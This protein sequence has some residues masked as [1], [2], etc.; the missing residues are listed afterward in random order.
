MSKLCAQ[1]D[2]HRCTSSSLQDQ[3]NSALNAFGQSSVLMQKDLRRLNN[4][5]LAL[6]AD[7]KTLNALANEMSSNL[8]HVT[9]MAEQSNANVFDLEFDKGSQC[10]W[11]FLQNMYRSR[12]KMDNQVACFLIL[13]AFGP[14]SD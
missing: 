4:R 13:V 12:Q 10:R 7:L 9:T 6:T 1:S 5:T 3:L 8:T 2:G 11:I 14:E